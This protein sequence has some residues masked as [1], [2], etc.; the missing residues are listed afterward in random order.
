[1]DALNGITNSVSSIATNGVASAWLWVGNFLVLV[2]ITLIMIGF[3]YKAGRGGIISLLVAFYVGYALYIVFPYT[4]DIV[5]AGGDPLIK[6]IISI[7]LY[8]IATFIPFRFIQR[9]VGNGFGVLSFLPRFVL[10]FLAATFLLAV[11]YHIF[12]VNNIYSLPAPINNLFEPN[13]YFFWW[14]VAPLLGLLFLVH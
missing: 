12:H 8:G 13:Q 3:S 11:A 6:A 1:M 7:V 2:I 4:N 14:F 5:K 10:S 9:L